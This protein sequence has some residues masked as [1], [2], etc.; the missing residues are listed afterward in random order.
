M[1]FICA[2]LDNGAISS[3]FPDATRRSVSQR[4][5]RCASRVSSLLASEIAGAVRPD[6]RRAFNSTSCARL[7]EC[8]K[9]SVLFWLESLQS[10]RHSAATWASM[11][12]KSRAV[13]SSSRAPS[14][15]NCSARS[16]SS[17]TCSR[18]PH[19]DLG[20]LG[21]CAHFLRGPRRG[22]G[23]PLRGLTPA[24]QR[25]REALRRSGASRACP[26]G[27]RRPRL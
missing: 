5:S 21:G 1:A 25:R 7:A 22:L 6:K 23:L 19:R 24:A 27:R 18:Q 2:V 12:A 8:C 26:P 13:P 3:E 9:V 20:G 17:L 14:S 16:R 10:C 11:T 15:T 4:N